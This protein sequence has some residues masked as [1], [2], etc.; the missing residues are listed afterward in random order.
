VNVNDGTALARTTETVLVVGGGMAGL[1]LA[2]A[3]EGSGKE[4]VIVERDAAPPEI[5][6]QDA[7]EQWK[8][9]GVWQFRYPHVFVG[10]LQALVRTRYPK[11]FE[12]LKQAGV[13]SSEF[14]EGLPPSLRDGYRPLDEDALMV[15]LCARRATLEYVLRRHVGRMPHVRFEHGA[16]AQALLSQREGGVLR[17]VG[18]EVKR[19]DAREELRGDVVVDAAGRNSPLYGWLQVLGGGIEILDE[20]SNFLYLSRHYRLR[21][22]EQEPPHRDVAGDLDYLKY[23]IFYGERGHFA[24]AFGC[25]EDETDLVSVLRRAEGFDAAC[26]QMPALV[27]WLSRSEPVTKVLGAAK[28]TNRWSRV[29][30]TPRVQGLFMLGD[31]GFEANPIYGRGCAA[32]FVQS[33]LLAEA[34]IAE[35][36]YER[37]VAKFEAG[38]RAEILPYHKASVLGDQL[39]RGRAERARGQRLQLSQ[40]LQIYAYD[41][42]IV[43]AVLV[44]MVLAREI[45]KTMSMVDPAGPLRALRFGLRVFRAWIFGRGRAAKQQQ[46]PA[47]PT[48]AELM[49]RIAVAAPAPAGAGQESIE[50]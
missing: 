7:F 50:P 19:G 31:A 22:G 23:A 15:S 34:L 28:I 26:A 27:P 30:D 13:R 24:V 2:L 29:S 25:A 33:H 14:V 44:D 6:P 32:A 4:L 46:L 8:R 1:S 47:G 42:M 39:F 35:S 40:R 43:P 49:E 17:I 45:I 3:L 21:D 10:R 48:R 38:L 12:E 37:R 18:V 5:E 36:G 9:P 16:A 20:P 11:L 41:K